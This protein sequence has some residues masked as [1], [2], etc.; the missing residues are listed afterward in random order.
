LGA[1]VHLARGGEPPRDHYSCRLLYDEQKKC[2]FGS[3]D[4]RTM[5]R[6]RNECLRAGGRAG[7]FMGAGQIS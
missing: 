6:L 1:A 4:K 5:E 3:C 2:A 7:D